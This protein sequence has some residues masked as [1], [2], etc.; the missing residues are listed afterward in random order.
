M[1]LFPLQTGR[2]PLCTN[3]HKGSP[4]SGWRILRNF[5]NPFLEESHFVHRRAKRG[6]DYNLKIHSARIRAC[7]VPYSRIQPI[8]PPKFNMAPEKWWLEDDPFLLGRYIFRGELLNFQGI[9]L[10]TYTWNLEMCSILGFEP[11]KRRPFPFK[12]RAIWVP[13]IYIYIHI[14]IYITP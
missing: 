13:G 1:E 9:I 6:Q 7:R 14:Y 12:T 4:S 5:A 11:S 2:V 3:S 8:T 10:Y